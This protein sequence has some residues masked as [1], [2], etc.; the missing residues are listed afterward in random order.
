M[1]AACSGPVASGP[2]DPDPPGPGAELDQSTAAEL[3]TLMAAWRTSRAPV[4]GR[5]EPF[6]IG[7]AGIERLGASG[8]VSVAWI[9]VDM[10]RFLDAREGATDAI[11]DALFHLTGQRFDE[12]VWVEA[13]N[14]LIAA[15]TPAPARYVEWKRVP[16]LTLEPGWAPFFDDP[17]SELDYRLVAWGGVLRDDRPVKEAVAGAR[18]FFGCIPVL[19]SPAVVPAG[20]GGWYPDE[21][22]VLGVSI[23]GEARAYPLNV[24]EFHEMI[25]DQLGGRRITLTFCTLCR[26]AQAY[27]IDRPPQGIE[28]VELRTSGL[29]QRSNKLMFDLNTDSLFDQFSGRALTGPLRTVDFALE[30]VGVVTS[31]WGRWKADH[32]NTT[33]VAEDGGIN[34]AYAADPLNGRDVGGPVFPIGD[35]DPRLAPHELVF[36]VSTEAGG[37]VAFPVSEA[38]STLEAGGAVA[39]GEVELVLDGGGLKARSA[40]G[41]PLAGQEAFWFAWSQFHPTTTIWNDG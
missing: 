12:P 17:E 40:D 18:C 33:I 9:L 37:S 26:S 39:I 2:E 4:L 28:E 11:G 41:A 8:Q 13:T 34:R 5:V 35:P 25:T 30:P 6:D 3:D 22:P 32:P 15:D 19:H 23:D 27:F 7:V 1:A 20:E 36:G 24:A 10:L 14:Y 29:L 21:Q 31:T 16:Y 38:R